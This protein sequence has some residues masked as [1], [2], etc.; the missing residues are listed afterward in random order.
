MPV[1]VVNPHHWLNEDGTFPDDT[2]VRSRI[3]RVA[4]CIESG[5]PLEIGEFRETLIA[6]RRRPGNVACK[7]LLWVAKQPDR[8]ILAYCGDCRQD[9]YIIHSWEET[10]WAQGPMEPLQLGEPT[11]SS[12]LGRA[13]FALESV[14]TEHDVQTMIATAPNP[15]SAIQRVVASLARTPTEP[16]LQNLVAELIKTWNQTPR[17]ELGGRAPEQLATTRSSQKVGRNARSPCGSGKKYKRCCLP[18]Q[19][20]H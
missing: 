3:L 2:R 5:G 8:T 7:G 9:E 20:V 17:P 13:L 6:C 18:T 10:L 15:S 16:E 11:P 4:Q 12:E 14:L 19:P 1:T